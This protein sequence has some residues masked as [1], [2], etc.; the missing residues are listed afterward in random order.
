MKKV[1]IYSTPACPF[2]IKA[3]EFFKYNG[4][5]YEEFNV[6]VDGKSRDEMIEKSGQISVPVIEIDGSII[7]GFKE[8]ELRKKLELEV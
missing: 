8:E 1:K 2:C 7:V 3:K 4:V 5:E 6:A